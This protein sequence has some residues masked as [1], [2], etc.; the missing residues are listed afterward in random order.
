MKWRWTIVA[1][2]VAVVVAVVGCVVALAGGS[3]GHPLPPPIT[4]PAQSWLQQ[5]AYLVPGDDSRVDVSDVAQTL[6]GLEPNYRTVHH[7]DVD[8]ATF[9]D[10]L[11]EQACI[12]IFGHTGRV[13]HALNVRRYRFDPQASGPNV[14]PLHPGGT[15]HDGYA[16][17]CGYSHGPLGGHLLELGVS[18]GGLTLHNL[19]TYAQV[20]GHGATG[21]LSFGR[22]PHGLFGRAQ[23]RAYLR[24]R[25]ARAAYLD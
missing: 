17:Q 21:G 19:R 4:D 3:T 8:G 1:A 16:L 22:R 10:D 14:S 12:Y 20:R 18:S 5:H 6:L 25:L 2:V 9:R 13:D 7:V 15:D 11:L 24:H 23:V